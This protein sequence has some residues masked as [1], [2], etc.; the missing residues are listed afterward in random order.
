LFLM[1]YA[2]RRRL[3]IWGTARIVEG[4][5]ALIAQLMPTNY[6]ARAE[7]VILFAVTAWDANCPQHIPQRFEAEDVARALAERDARISELEQELARLKNP[8]WSQPG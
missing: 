7:Q 5:H 3:K 8:V 6:Q 1:D 4:D 2:N